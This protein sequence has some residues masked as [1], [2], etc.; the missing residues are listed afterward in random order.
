M[1][2]VGKET[3]ELQALLEPKRETEILSAGGTTFVTVW[4]SGYKRHFVKANL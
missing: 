2:V 3:R 1:E 4:K